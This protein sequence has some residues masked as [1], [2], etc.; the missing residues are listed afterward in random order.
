VFDP[1]SMP[2][3][4]PLDVVDEAASPEPPS[5]I[6]GIDFAPDGTLGVAWTRVEPVG[7]LGSFRVY[8][9]RSIAAG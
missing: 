6:V 9:S 8:F 3:L 2:E 4:V 5:E 1:G 7:P